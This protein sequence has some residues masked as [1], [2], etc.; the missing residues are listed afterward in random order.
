MS[1]HRSQSKRGQWQGLKNQAGVLGLKRTS[2]KKPDNKAARK[3]I[4][5]AIKEWYSIERRTR[6]QNPNKRFLR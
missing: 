1:H 5:E 2:E 6:E 4:R 3:R